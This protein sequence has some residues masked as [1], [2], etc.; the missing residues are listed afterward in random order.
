MNTFFPLMFPSISD[1]KKMSLASSATIQGITC[2]VLVSVNRG[3]KIQDSS[4]L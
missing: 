3:L 2:N 4:F 1:N